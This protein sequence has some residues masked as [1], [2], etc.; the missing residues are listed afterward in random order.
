MVISALLNSCGADDGENARLV[1]ID[2]LLTI[3]LDALSVAPFTPDS[4]AV[5]LHSSFFVHN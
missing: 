5:I 3:R 2:K 4:A 1:V